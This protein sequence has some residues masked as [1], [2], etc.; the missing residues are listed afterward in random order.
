MCFRCCHLYIL[1]VC[2]RSHRVVRY[3]DLQEGVE[4]VV[5]AAE[6]RGDGVYTI[7]PVQRVRV[8]ESKWPWRRLIFCRAVM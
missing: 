5:A 8:V 3:V 6:S 4:L 1:Q 2:A 7:T